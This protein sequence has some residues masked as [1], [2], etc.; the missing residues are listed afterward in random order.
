[1]FLSNTALGPGG[2]VAGNNITSTNVTYQ[3]NSATDVGGGVYAVGLV[4]TDND[5]F[6]DNSSQA[7]GGGIASGG[8]ISLS[9][10]QLIANT[11]NTGGGVYQSSGSGLIVN[12]L[13]AR[14]TALGSSGAALS[15]AP[16][17]TTQV[18]HTT[19]ASPTV[20]SGSALFVNGGAVS[21]I[22]TIIASHTLGIVQAAGVVNADYNLF[23]GNIVNTQGGGIT[24]NHPRSG[25]PGF[26]NPWSEDYH[27]GVSSAA[28][29]T[30]T[31]AGII[32]DFDGEARPQ[33]SGFDIGYDEASP[34]EGL[35]AKN[36][37]PTAVGNP[38]TFI[39]SVTF[40]RAVSYQW[41]F[42]DGSSGSGSPAMH[43]YTT[44]GQYLATVTA[45]N[46][47]GSLTA[48]TTVQVIA[49]YIYLPV[50]KR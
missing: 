46:G 43:V 11:A 4:T 1:L 18:L 17:G 23:F 36:D 13:F 49:N 35:S 48:Q 5:L 41:D 2:A 24:N 3:S 31:N 14:N 12:S 21:L 50:I 40:G 22:D 16:S 20:A 32:I 34:P 19:I 29:N 10:T 38:T 47:A 15:L 28:V 9:R 44:P 27:L 45:A 33:G 42:G 25:N 30:G 8:K 39:A 26:F 7:N 37:G 6:Q